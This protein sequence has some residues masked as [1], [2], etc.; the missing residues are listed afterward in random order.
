MKLVI[1]KDECHKLTKNLTKRLSKLSLQKFNF[2]I[3]LVP[4]VLQILG[5][6]GLVKVGFGKGTT[7]NVTQTLIIV[8]GAT[9]FCW[10]LADAIMFG[11]NKHR[12]R[13]DVPLA[14]W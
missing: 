11:L 10:W 13:Y 1:Q 2:C 5:C 4:I 7:A 8:F 6:L 12:D 9:A 3:M 14:K